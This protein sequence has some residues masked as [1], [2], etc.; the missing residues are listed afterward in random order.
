MH[1][2]LSATLPAVTIRK[3][4][5]PELGTT[6]DELLHR[7]SSPLLFVALSR[8]GRCTFEVIVTVI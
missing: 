1:I 5:M 4:H 8:R 6:S 7:R 2:S 3:Q